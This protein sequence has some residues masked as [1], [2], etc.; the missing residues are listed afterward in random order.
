M[1]TSYFCNVFCWP[2]HLVTCGIDTITRDCT[3]RREGES[4]SGD[5]GRGELSHRTPLKHGLD[6]RPPQ[7]TAMREKAHK[8]PG[9]KAIARVWSPGN[10]PV[11][12]AGGLA[13]G[14]HS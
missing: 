3:L 2:L 1:R 13:T 10:H 12:Y 8:P 9:H 6:D 11:W 5:V 7:N 14:C 4:E